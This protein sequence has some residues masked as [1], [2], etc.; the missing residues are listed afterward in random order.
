MATD[1]HAVQAVVL[2][3]RPS[4]AKRIAN[5]VVLLRP[6]RLFFGPVFQKEMRTLGRRKG[7]YILRAIYALLLFAILGI[8]FWGESDSMSERVDATALQDIALPAS[9]IIAWTQFICLCLVSSM[10]TSHAIV[11]EKVGRTIPALAT[12]PLTSSQIILNKLASRFIQLLVLVL[13]PVPVLLAMRVLGGVEADYIFGA[14]MLA[15]SSS[16]LGLSLGMFFSVKGKDAR[17]SAGRAVFVMLLIM[18]GPALIRIVLSPWLGPPARLR[19]LYASSSPLTLG[20]LTTYQLGEM[21]PGLTPADIKWIWIVNTTYMFGLSLLFALASTMTF[22]KLMQIESAGGVGMVVRSRFRVWN[23]RKRARSA[24]QISNTVVAAS[25]VSGET[26]LLHVAHTPVVVGGSRVVGDAPVL[27]RELRRNSKK[28]SLSYI[29]PRTLFDQLVLAWSKFMPWCIGVFFAGALIEAFM[30]VIRPASVPGFW[31]LVWSFVLPAVFLW[32]VFR[33]RK[34]KEKRH[35]LSLA[36]V[37]A[38]SVLFAML[39]ILA[40]FLKMNNWP[41]SWVVESPAPAFSI[42]VVVGFLVTVVGAATTSVG[43]IVAERESQTWEMLLTTPLRARDIIFGKVIGTVHQQAQTLLF[44]LLV[45]GFAVGVGSLHPVVILVAAM[46]MLGPVVYLAGTGALLATVFRRSTSASIANLFVGFAT[47]LGPWILLGIVSIL[48]VMDYKAQEAFAHLLQYSSPFVYPV[49]A[50]V[51]AGL[52]EHQYSLS[53]ITWYQ[54]DRFLVDVPGENTTLAPFTVFAVLCGGLH[55]V[56][57]VFAAF[58]AA[59]RLSMQTR[60]P[61]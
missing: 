53:G 31:F 42:I 23:R 49:V 44:V 57:G 56:V 4:I 25:P 2:R 55:M 27:W 59:R 36:H 13:I 50:V 12:T 61:M 14:T 19:E 52:G 10:L 1:A 38:W 37:L 15:L 47:W 22:R 48:G 54:F 16:A 29:R 34:E 3:P 60:R 26:S 51:Q 9:F 58:L 18:F 8:Y 17:R 11:G 28:G 5:A 21:P 43:S 20:A 45:I 7:T 30:F 24:V 6:E 39:A 41:M 40:V 46:C 33:L 35:I 32:C